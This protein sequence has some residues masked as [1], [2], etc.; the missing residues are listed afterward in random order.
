MKKGISPI[1]AVIILIGV[2]ITIGVM[3]SGW[4][5]QWVTKQT[6]STSA[7]CVINTNYVIESAIYNES[8]GDTLVIKL[9]NKD[10]EE[11]YGFNVQL[12]NNTNIK[13]FNSSNSIYSESPYSFNETKKL[14]ESYTAFIKLNLTSYTGMA[15]TMTEIRI[16]NVVCQ[17]V[18]ATTNIIT[19]YPV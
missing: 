12:M 15:T 16:T 10:S 2:A 9:T 13:I 17:G 8:G 1:I 6:Q 19:T 3:L 4:V 11:L 18:Y 14:K 7:S 5:T